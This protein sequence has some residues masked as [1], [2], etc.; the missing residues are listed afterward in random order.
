MDVFASD[1]WL[2]GC[3]YTVIENFQLEFRF[4]LHSNESTSIVNRLL[5]LIWYFA[6]FFPFSLCVCLF[7]LMCMCVFA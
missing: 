7:L 2:D 4:T 3:L 5:A 6:S 1:G